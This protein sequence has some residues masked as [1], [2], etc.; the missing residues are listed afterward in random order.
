MIGGQTEC[1]HL[2][3]VNPHLQV[4]SD[5]ADQVWGRT[6]L[7]ALRCHRLVGM[8]VQQQHLVQHYLPQLWG[9]LSNQ[10]QAG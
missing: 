1:F 7:V 9:E 2:L 6:L 3:T 8:D 4:A 5:P 10:L